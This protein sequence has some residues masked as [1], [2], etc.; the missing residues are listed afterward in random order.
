M[1]VSAGLYPLK[2]KS[3]VGG[4]FMC[5]DTTDSI[6]GRHLR[7]YA[8]HVSQVEARQDGRC[9]FVQNIMRPEPRGCRGSGLYAVVGPAPFPLGAG[10]P[11]SSGDSLLS[12]KDSSRSL[13]A[14]SRPPF[15]L[16]PARAT[17]Q[18]EPVVAASAGRCAW[19][20]NCR[21]AGGAP[22]TEPT[23]DQCGGVSSRRDRETIQTKRVPR[24]RLEVLHGL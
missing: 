9:R 18:D 19:P 12:S 17:L 13:K 6:F 23:A 10:R 8:H 1:D 16:S 22:R 4:R 15:F 7:T 24:G 11:S 21:G 3:E 20:R 14:S 5:A 2:P